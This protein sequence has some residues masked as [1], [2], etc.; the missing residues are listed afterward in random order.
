[1]PSDG[2]V[3]RPAAG[4][5]DIGDVRALFIEYARSLDF[6]LC[7]QGFDAE[8]AS[9]PGAYAPPGGCILLARAD[10]RAVGVVAVR[11]L[12]GD[13]CEMK[14][15]Y[16]RPEG[17]GTGLG[18]SLAEAIVIAARRAG[19]RAMRLDTH[20]SMTAAVALYRSLGFTEIAAYYDNPLAGIHYFERRLG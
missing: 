6:S 3:I 9:L 17:R 8:I 16:V 11:P 5:A 7:F 2:A 4:A 12:A 19:Y 18:R 20:E 1:M 13:T 15:L 14:R 10:D